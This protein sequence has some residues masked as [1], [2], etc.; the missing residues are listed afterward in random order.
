MKI[1]EYL[2][3]KN[4]DYEEK[5]RPSGINYIMVCPFCNG[6]EHNRITFAINANTGLWNCKRENDCGKAG[7]FFQLQEMLGDNPINFEPFRK[8]QSLLNG[9]KK[10]EGIFKIPI[11]QRLELTSRVKNYLINER[12]IPENIIKKFDI[13][14]GYKA[15]I[16]F[17]Y[18]KNGKVVNIKHRTL[19]KKFWQENNAESCLYNIDNINKKND[20]LVITEGELDCISLYI[21]GM[22]NIVSIPGGVDDFRWIDNDWEF[23]K[24]FKNILLAIDMDIAG[25]KKIKKLASRLGIWRCRNVEL[26]YKDANKCLQEGISIEEIKEYFTNSIE[27][28]PVELKRAGEYC[29]EVLDIYKN[30]DKYKGIETG[31]PEL[32]KLLGGWRSHEVTIWTGQNSS[33]KTTLLNQLCIFLGSRKI[34]CCIA[35]LEL[36]AARY[37]KWATNQILGI[38]FPNEDDIIKAFEWMNEWLYIIDI[39]D[40]VYGSK[41]FDVFEYAA[42]RYGIEHFI[43][44][45]LMKIKLKG[46]DDENKSQK[47][48]VNDLKRF[49]K[50]FGVHCHLV[51]HPR[52]QEKDTDKPDKAAVK[53]AGEITDLA[54]NVLILWRNMEDKEDVEENERIDAI[55]TLRKNREFGRIGSIPLFFNQESR[56]YRCINQENIF[57]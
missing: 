30:P 24:N 32:T 57:Y 13:F 41:I 45:S 44:D 47:D 37:L 51:A 19:E 15:E 17:P 55:L 29:E 33:G 49:T 18:Y 2:D 50:H 53:G 16:C 48:F 38:E 5:V 39:D 46:G 8:Q 21:Y 23:L 3:K 54:D 27:F 7:T 28:K 6:G 1:T 4:F 43:I 20:T 12:K 10:K 26:P 14:S 40:S 34:K 22:S 31:L 25:R 52:K 11:F 9:Y 35:S 56:R 42:R 36:R